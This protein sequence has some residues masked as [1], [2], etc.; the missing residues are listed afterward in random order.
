MRKLH[1]LTLVD[2][3]L[4]H[5]C[6]EYFTSY[7]QFLNQGHTLGTRPSGKLLIP[8]HRTEAFSKSFIVLGAK[9]WNQ[10]PNS[11]MDTVPFSI[12]ERVV[13]DFLFNKELLKTN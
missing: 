9:Y 10:L 7:F 6:P 2:K 5:C 11:K 1:I 13:N 3:T 4:N 12:V 8:K